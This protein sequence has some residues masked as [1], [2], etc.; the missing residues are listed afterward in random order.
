MKST[1]LKPI[2]EIEEEI[3]S[4]KSPGNGAG[5]FWCFGSS[6]IARNGEDVFVSGVEILEDFKP[7]NNTK[8]ILYKRTCDGWEIQHRDSGRTREPAP[9]VTLDN[10]VFLSANP[11]LTSADE[12]RG[13]AEPQIIEFSATD[14]NK[15]YNIILPQW[16]NPPQWHD[17]SYR[18]FAADSNN[19][20]MILFNQNAYDRS[21]WSLMDSYGKSISKGQI[22]FPVWK[23]SE[24]DE[25]MRLCYPNVFIKNKA[26]YFFGVSD[27]YEP[28]KEWNAA[29]F[30]VTNRD[31]D[32]VYRYIF[33]AYTPDITKQPFGEWQEISNL[34]KTAG[35]VRNWDMWVDK[36]GKVYLLW[37]ERNLDIR[38]RDEFFPK[39]VYT[40]SLKY[41]VLDKG[42]ITE[43]HTLLEWNENTGGFVAD[44]ARFQILEDERIVVIYQCTTTYPEP[45]N[46][47]KNPIDNPEIYVQEITPGKG[48]AKAIKL[49]LTKPF[50]GRFMTATP[51]SGNKISNTLD[52]LGEK[53]GKVNYIRIRF[54]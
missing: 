9:L 40:V 37:T 41:A 30:K 33:L 4:Y 54:E 45:N 48:P 15:P 7:V 18:S 42:K 13:P 10:K 49:P 19:N 39:E 3:Y 35:Y 26:V 2:V 52:I 12:S 43:Q 51:R 38:I 11:T 34:E 8:W 50:Q 14:T 44:S 46:Q 29:R 24:K 36:H 22:M 16:D 47:R 25:P 32:Y 1:T 27:I 21:W 23:G 6:T 53:D 28:V 17:H 20:Q 31:W 5:P